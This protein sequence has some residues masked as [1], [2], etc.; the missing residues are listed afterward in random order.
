MDFLDASELAQM[1]MRLTEAVVQIIA[2]A[3]VILFVVSLFTIAWLC[4][5]EARQLKRGKSVASE[6]QHEND[7]VPM[8]ITVDNGDAGSHFWPAVPPRHTAGLG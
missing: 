6:T 5:S 1:K 2:M 8:L 3:T 4:S 7:Q